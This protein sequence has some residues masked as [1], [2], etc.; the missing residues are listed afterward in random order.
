MPSIVRRN[1]EE[2]GGNAEPE[3]RYE[4]IGKPRPIRVDPRRIG[5]Q[6]TD[7]I[8][9]SAIGFQNLRP[10]F[11]RGGHTLA[12]RTQPPHDRRLH[13][14]HELSAQVARFCR[15]PPHRPARASVV[16]PDPYRLAIHGVHGP[17]MIETLSDAPS[18]AVARPPIELVL[19][20]R[21]RDHEPTRI[22]V[23]DLLEDLLQ[24]R[25]ERHASIVA[26]RQRRGRDLRLVIR[27]SD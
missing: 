17:E 16:D 5:N 25:W 23:R 11:H 12:G 24:F 1:H 14:L 26:R 7:E 6:L 2:T 3:E 27:I 21:L 22:R 8:M 19:R 10:L 13:R 4:R 9:S 20:A 15:S 18:G